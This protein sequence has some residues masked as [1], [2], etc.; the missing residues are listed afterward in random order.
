MRVL[1]MLLGLIWWS[2]FVTSKG[3]SNRNIIS[4]TVH[5]YNPICLTHRILCPAYVLS[6][7]SF[8]YRTQ[9]D[10]HHDPE[11]VVHWDRLVGTS[12]QQLWIPQPEVHRCRLRFC[13]ALQRQLLA[14]AH[15]DGIVAC[16]DRGRNWK[17]TQYYRLNATLCSHIQFTTS[18]TR[19]LTVGGTPLEAM[20]R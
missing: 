20:Q 9:G 6:E 4:L 13:D 3:L 18:M 17:I 1:S 16:P 12:L 5:G 7:I 14:Q 10:P 15:V 19:L 11:D 8:R 2:T